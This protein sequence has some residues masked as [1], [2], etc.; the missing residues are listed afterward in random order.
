M[1]KLTEKSIEDI[2]FDKGKLTKD[3]LSMVKMESIK[4]GK[5]I[6]QV[7]L[8]RNFASLQDITQ[9]IGRASCRERV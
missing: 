8:E 2:L 5:Q 6:E 4:T 3:K 1:A 9:E 7:L